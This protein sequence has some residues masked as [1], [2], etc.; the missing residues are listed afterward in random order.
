MLRM[1]NESL[2]LEVAKYVSASQKRRGDGH[3]SGDFNT[4]GETSVDAEG[5]VTGLLGS[6][7]VPFLLTQEIETREER[8]KTY[9]RNKISELKIEREELKSKTEHYVK[10]VSVCLILNCIGSGI[11]FQI[12]CCYRCFVVSSNFVC[13]NKLVI[14]VLP[15]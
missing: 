11:E 5:R 14:K 12:A 1:E 9:F 15:N 4:F 6:L 13:Y 3:D 7:Q 10:E 2:K 8:M